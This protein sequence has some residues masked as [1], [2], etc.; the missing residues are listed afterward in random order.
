MRVILKYTKDEM[1][2]CTKRPFLEQK[3]GLSH[4]FND[5][6][7]ISS[8]DEKAILKEIDVLTLYCLPNKLFVHFK[9]I[10]SNKMNL[11]KSNNF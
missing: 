11:L 1:D 2:K 10:S 6:I 3:N 8:F 9:S 7:E 5:G 4:C